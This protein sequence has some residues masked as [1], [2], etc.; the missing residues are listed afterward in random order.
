MNKC[1]FCG[2][3]TADPEVRTSQNGMT[4]ARFTL[5]VDRIKRDE[6]DFIRCISFDK[7]G[8]FAEKYLKKEMKILV[9]AHVQTGSYNDKD[10]R[11]VYTTDFVIDRQEFVERR[12]E[13]KT[14]AKP[15]EEKKEKKEDESGF[16]N[17]PDDVEDLGLPWS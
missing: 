4:I 1:I 5:A 13:G 8:E 7:A 14:E 3:L 16:M 6:A 2:R 10:G 15:K 9:E 17:I 12:E 11:K